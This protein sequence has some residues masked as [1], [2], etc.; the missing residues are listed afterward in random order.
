MFWWLFITQQWKNFNRFLKPGDRVDWYNGPIRQ[1]YTL[2]KLDEFTAE[3]RNNTG[4]IKEV[5]RA[6]LYPDIFYSYQPK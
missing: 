6:D 4:K 2:E 1:H 3:I 5:N